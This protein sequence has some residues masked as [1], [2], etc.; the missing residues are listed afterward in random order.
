MNKPIDINSESFSGLK[1]TS[2]LVYSPEL[3]LKV[4]DC[5]F[6][7]TFSS[8]GG[9]AIYFEYSSATFS[10]YRSGFYHCR[11]SKNTLSAGAIY[12]HIGQYILFNSLCFSNCSA[13]D[14][15]TN[16]QIA[17]QNNIISYVAVNLS[18]EEN[19]GKNEYTSM[20]ASH[21]GGRV[22]TLCN[23]HNVTNSVTVGSEAG[24]VFTRASNTVVRFMT[25]NNNKGSAIVRIFSSCSS[26][27]SIYNTNICNNTITGSWFIFVSSSTNVVLTECIFLYN[28]NRI[29]QGSGGTILFNNCLFDTDVSASLVSKTGVIAYNAD[30][31]NLNAIPYFSTRNCWNLGQIPSLYVPKSNMRSCII[32]VL[33]NMLSF[34]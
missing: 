20:Y 24:I 17:N 34:A 3:L 8:T 6:Y 19:S 18:T 32:Y 28:Y 7:D 31:N 22:S 15:V 9:G 33:G 26:P 2:K 1:Y 12:V 29:I 5:S 30:V 4:E 27:I 11:S 23:Y 25:L 10:C 16:F 14:D 13:N 21:I